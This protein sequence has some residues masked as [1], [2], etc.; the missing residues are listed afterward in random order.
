M[1]FEF[2][3]RLHKRLKEKQLLKYRSLL[4]SKD[5]G[6][7]RE[8]QGFLKAIEYFGELLNNN[9]PDEEKENK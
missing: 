1:D 6:D 7:I 9:G 5:S 4:N 3:E 2:L 8:I